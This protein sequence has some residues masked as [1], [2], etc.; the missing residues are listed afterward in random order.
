MLK[1]NV[2]GSQAGILLDT[3]TLSLSKPLKIWEQAGL[4]SANVMKTT[5]VSWMLFGVYQTNDILVKM[6]LRQS[7]ACLGCSEMNE[8]L[9]HI[10]FECPHYQK[11]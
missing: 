8:S 11:I 6:K 1:K 9:S 10:I 3:T 5:V 4:C 7:A 2:E